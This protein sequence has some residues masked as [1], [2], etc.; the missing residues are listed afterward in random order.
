[1]PNANSYEEIYSLPI[2]PEAINDDHIEQVVHNYR[3]WIKSKMNNLWVWDFTDPNIE[4]HHGVLMP[5]RE[6][7]KHKENSLEIEVKKDPS[8]SGYWDD[9][10]MATEMMAVAI[11]GSM[12]TKSYKSKVL[13]GLPADFPHDIRVIKNLNPRGRPVF[14]MVSGQLE[15]RFTKVVDGIDSGWATVEV[16]LSAGVLWKYVKNNPDYLEIEIRKSGLEEI[17]NYHDRL[18]IRLLRNPKKDGVMFHYPENRSVLVQHDTIHGERHTD[19]LRFIF[20]DNRFNQKSPYA[21][22][23]VPISMLVPQKG[24]ISSKQLRTWLKPMM[25]IVK[26]QDFKGPEANMKDDIF[27]DLANIM[28]HQGVLVPEIGYQFGIKLEDYES[29]FNIPMEI[30]EEVYDLLLRSFKAFILLR[31]PQIVEKIKA[32]TKKELRSRKGRNKR[33]I[34]VWGSNKVRYIYPPK[35]TGRKLPYHFVRGHVRRLSNGNITNVRPYYKGDIDVGHSDNS[36]AIGK[37]SKAGYS[38]MALDW[39]RSIEASEGISIQHAESG[40]E[41]RV[42]HSKGHY[43]VD[44]YCK[45]TNTVYEFH[46][47]IWHGNPLCFDPEDCPHPFRPEITAR[48]LHEATLA[49]EDFLRQHFN[50]VTIWESDWMKNGS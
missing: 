1:M 46:G 35:N 30:D 2:Y 7:A 13:R 48:Q 37:S 19:V 6:Y 9:P 25:T 50:V 12:R 42:R 4:G 11:D 18:D 26:Q 36:M 33:S 40:G 38:Q 23:T 3:D 5:Y 32:D 34:K 10:F 21:G 29:N 45:A 20:I 41:L 47:D 22:V 31:S 16:L 14:E 49:K 24:I 17:D 15:Y 8:L 44:G 27:M 28:M 43:L 39:L